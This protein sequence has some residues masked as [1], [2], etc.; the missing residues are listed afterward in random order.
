ME[1]RP[2][3]QY[4]LKD[5]NIE[6]LT[7]IVATLKLIEYRCEEISHKNEIRPNLVK[8]YNLF[9]EK[10]GFNNDELYHLKPF[11]FLYHAWEELDDL[12][13]N[14]YLENINLTNIANET[15]KQANLWLDKNKTKEV[16]AKEWKDT[17]EDSSGSVISSKAKNILMHNLQTERSKY[18][19]FSLKLPK[20]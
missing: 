2:Y 17:H 12:G 10:D 20:K 16:D 15:I 18:F 7:G 1:I 8:L 9:I 6:E 14:F 5:F 19:H 3:V 11:Y 13:V 4:V